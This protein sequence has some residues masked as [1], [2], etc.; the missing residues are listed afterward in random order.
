MTT[1]V[2]RIEVEPSLDAPVPDRISHMFEEKLDALSQMMAEHMAAPF[3]PGLR[4]LSIE[5]R[6]M[7]LLDAD[8]YAYAA[9]VLEG[10]LDEQ[11]RAGLIRLTAAFEKVLPA[12]GDEYGAKYYTHVRGM[13]VLA[14]EIET[15]R[16]E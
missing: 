7:V 9:V 1:Q 6:D 5:G 11:R 10:P 15:L 8:S 13:A 2:H 3:P 16:G 4:G 12:I 14:A